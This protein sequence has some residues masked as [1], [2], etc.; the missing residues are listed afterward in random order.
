MGSIEAED[1]EEAAETGGIFKRTIH[2]TNVLQ[3]ERKNRPRNND[4][5]M[6]NA[7]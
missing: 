4:G 5:S 2:I 7:K 6:Q 3:D 1:E